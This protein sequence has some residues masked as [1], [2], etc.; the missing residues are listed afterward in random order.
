MADN[1]AQNSFEWMLTF[2]TVTPPTQTWEDNDT[3][4]VTS[5]GTEKGTVLEQWKYDMETNTWV[6]MPKVSSTSC[7]WP[8]TAQTN[9]TGRLQTWS[10]P[11]TTSTGNVETDWL[12]VSNTVTSPDCITDLHVSIDFWVLYY[13]LRRMRMYQWVDWRIMIN[14]VAVY[15]ETFDEY[16]YE[17]QREDTNPDVI[18]PLDVRSHTMWHSNGIRLNVPAWATVWV[19]VKYRHNFNAP[20]TSAYGRLIQWL[21]SQA[22]FVFIPKSLV[23]NITT[24]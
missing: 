2:W 23:T 16:N 20:Q 6:K 14:W 15:T 21:R 24:S 1:S 18:R 4:I 5:D 7:T 8:F 17:S 12:P 9:R 19:E 10:T 3:Y 11:A 13:Q 22:T